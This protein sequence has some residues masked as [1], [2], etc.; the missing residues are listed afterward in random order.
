M[1]LRHNGVTVVPEYDRKL[2]EVLLAVDPSFGPHEM[3]RFHHPL[4]EALPRY[5]Q[6]SF[7]VAQKDSSALKAALIGTG[8]EKRTQIL[9]IE[10]FSGLGPWSQ[11][12]GEIIKRGNEYVLLTPHSPSSSGLNKGIRE[13]LKAEGIKV[14]ETDLCFGGG[15]ITFDVIDEK[16]NVFVG[17]NAIHSTQNSATSLFGGKPI[18]EI[19][20]EFSRVFGGAQVNVLGN[21]PLRIPTFHLDQ[22]VLILD[23]RRA[24]V[25][26][27]IDIE[28]PIKRS[29]IIEEGAKRLAEQTADQEIR[30]ERKRS[31]RDILG[32]KTFEE[33][34]LREILVKSCTRDYIE[35]LPRHI[36]RH[37][38]QIGI[39]I[40]QLRE[41]GYEITRMPW[42]LKQALSYQSYTNAVPY[43]D[44]NTRQQKI[45]VPIYPDDDGVYRMQGPNKEALD[46]Y[47]RKLG[48]EPIPLE[49]KSFLNRGNS[50]CL[51][52]V[53]R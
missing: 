23:G 12:I 30:K 8:T 40:Q 2:E 33:I 41:L 26:D 14:E 4:L 47:S 29:E 42:P 20:R 48:Y 24:V 1:G 18:A 11:D 39:I 46:I 21:K 45:L 37:Q 27:L 35:L 13:K 31:W 53:F 3:L 36:T 15:D 6:T 22:S 51:M 10:D 28:D 44:K 17:Y 7:I 19:K 52:N 25:N 32:K 16:L 43:V 50:H 34:N 9:P 49:N 5:T 38:E